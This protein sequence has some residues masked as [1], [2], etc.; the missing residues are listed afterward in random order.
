[1]GARFSLTVPRYPNLWPLPKQKR[2][3]APIT[4][5]VVIVPLIL[6][7]AYMGAYYALLV[8]RTLSPYRSPHEIR[9]SIPC[10]RFAGEM[11][12]WILNPAHEIDARIRYAYWNEE[13]V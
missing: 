6:F 10:Y 4:A 1:M 11:T 9:P 3:V 13:D 5:L 8:G 2:P 12:R 7:S